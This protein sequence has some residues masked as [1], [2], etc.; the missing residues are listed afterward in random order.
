MSDTPRGYTPDNPSVSP[1]DISQIIHQCPVVLVQFL[2]RVIRSPGHRPTDCS[3]PLRVCHCTRARTKCVHYFETGKEQYPN[4]IAFSIVNQ[5]PVPR[6]GSTT[7][8]LLIRTCNKS[9]IYAY[10]HTIMFCINYPNTS[11]VCYI[12]VV[13]IWKFLIHIL[14]N[15]GVQVC[16]F[17]T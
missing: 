11:Q 1:A 8:L 14:S 2:K 7:V 13:T 17:E 10:I 4:T 9:Q 15:V 3:Y 16:F 12:P 6:Y 5:V